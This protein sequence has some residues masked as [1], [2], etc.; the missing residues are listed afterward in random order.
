LIKN[1]E[2]GQFVVQALVK[3]I[4]NKIVSSNVASD[5]ISEMI[6]NSPKESYSL[7]EREI[8]SVQGEI[9]ETGSVSSLTFKTL[10]SNKTVRLDVIKGII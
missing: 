5:E 9:L 2:S 1:T 8:Y 7:N 6:L 10:M 4:K 3:E